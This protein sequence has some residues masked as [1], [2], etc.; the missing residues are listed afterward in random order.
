VHFDPVPARA[1]PQRL[2]DR[3]VG[4]PDPDP[5]RRRSRIVGIDG[6]EW[7]G[8]GR[9]ADEVADAV[10]ATG[11]PVRRVA[12][13]DWQRTASLRLEFARDDPY[14][15]LYGWFDDAALTRELITPLHENDPVLLR[16]RDPGTDRPYRE[17]RHPLPPGT[18]VVLDGP[19]LA[20][21]G[22]PFDLLVHLEMSPAA[23]RRTLPADRAWWQE[24]FDRYAELAP[25][26]TA[27]VVV[28]WDHP[29]APA[30]RR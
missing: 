23:F 1:L 3:V 24:A 14:S 15:L 10:A 21:P 30:I 2:A 16:L 22:Y 5:Q 27:D 29:G 26:D 28:A 9:L 17:T 20:A 7:S 8:A 25:A 12:L 18:V 11:R 6:P 19:F 4:L 13:A